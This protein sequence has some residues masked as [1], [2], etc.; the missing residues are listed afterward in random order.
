M[1]CNE[2][3]S[4]FIHC[5]RVSIVSYG[6]S[7]LDHGQVQ[8]SSTCDA[9]FFS[10]ISLRVVQIVN[11]IDEQTPNRQLTGRLLGSGSQSKVDC[12]TCR[13]RGMYGF[14]ESSVMQMGQCE[15][16][17][18]NF[19]IT[20]SNCVIIMLYWRLDLRSYEQLREVVTSN[21]C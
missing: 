19:V 5:Y 6:A 14:S 11:I 20:M 4:I 17:M 12:I 16:M 3:I 13:K 18:Y 9:L 15:H 2:L 1:Y 21:G 10:S 7:N 8:V